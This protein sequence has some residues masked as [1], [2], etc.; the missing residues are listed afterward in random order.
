MRS[1]VL[2]TLL[3]RGLKVA[4]LLL[5]TTGAAAAE[6]WRP[7]PG[8]SFQWQL[9]SPVDPE[10]EAEVYD[11]DLFDTDATT[12]ALLKARGRWVICYVS[13]G[14]VE[15][16]RPDAHLF[17][18][19]VVGRQYD[20]WPGERWLDVRRLDLLAPVLGA[21]LD[22]CKAKGFDAVEPDNLDGYENE[23][24]FTLTRED[25]VRFNLWIAAEAHRRGL[26]IGLK[27][28]PEM[29][30]EMLSAFDWALTEDCFDQGWCAELAPFVDAGKAVFVTEYT[31]TGVNFEAACA[32]AASFGFTAILK[33]R[34]LGAFREVCPEAEA[35]LESLRW[36]GLRYEPPE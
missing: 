32:E 6:V 11:V 31:D 30:S 26:S 13:V 23:T 1:P 4:A 3:A 21:R 8:T 34:D 27:N 19:R 18:S 24:G 16:W 10:V 28:S 25:Q 7:A 22:L 5:A 17:P 14:T 2:P 15:D 29:V 33:E 35:E 12:V 20:E 9:D 36:P